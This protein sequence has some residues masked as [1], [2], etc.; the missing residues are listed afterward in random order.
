[1]AKNLQLLTNARKCY[2]N[3]RIPCLM[4]C[5][6]L[7]SKSLSLLLFFWFFL[8]SQTVKDIRETYASY[9][10]LHLLKLWC[11]CKNNDCHRNRQKN[12]RILFYILRGDPRFP[13][14]YQIPISASVLCMGGL[15]IAKMTVG[16]PLKLGSMNLP[17][18][19]LFLTLQI[20]KGLYIIRK[21]NSN[22]S[23]KLYLF[24]CQKHLQMD[25]YFLQ[26]T[27]QFIS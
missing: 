1:M 11:K 10:F 13:R 7:Q 26:S 3:W 8:V 12:P 2:S 20:L 22:V 16:F 6:D 4:P 24:C 9:C 5:N 19:C 23:F 15:I 18:Q 25:Y 14:L 27:F 21:G 17:N